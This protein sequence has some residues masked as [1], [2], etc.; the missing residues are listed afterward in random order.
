[1]Q[2][3][4]VTKQPDTAPPCDLFTTEI[5]VTI[6]FCL[7]CFSSCLFRH[8]VYLEYNK[9]QAAPQQHPCRHSQHS[10]KERG[11]ALSFFLKNWWCHPTHITGKQCFRSPDSKLLAIGFHPCYLPQEITNVIVIIVYIPPSANVE[12]TCDI[13]CTVYAGLQ[14]KHPGACI[15]ITSI[16]LIFPLTP[17]VLIH[18]FNVQPE[19]I[20]LWTCSMVMLR[21]L[22]AALERTV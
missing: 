11:R 7:F 10:V 22:T 8:T 19:K 17:T 21:R 1:M 15:T 9:P 20:R 2:D 4:T 3:G 6:C 16:M 18:L 5:F 14:S 12:T 13:I